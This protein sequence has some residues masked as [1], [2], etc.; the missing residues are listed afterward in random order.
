[1]KPV[2]LTTRVT[3][4]RLGHILTL[5]SLVLCAGV[6][7]L[8]PTASYAADGDD[9]AQSVSSDEVVD[10]SD[11]VIT[12]GHVDLGPKMV[13]GTWTVL[14]RDDSGNTPVWRDVERTVLVVNDA[15]LL[16]APTDAPYA[17]MEATPGEKW[18]VIPQTENHSSVWLGWNTQDPEVTR[19]V[20]R[21]VTMSIGPVEGP[22]KS[23]MFLQNGT[24]GEPLLLVDGQKKEAQDVWV[25]VNTHVHA[26]WVFTK[27]GVYLATLT[28]SA[29]TRDGGQVSETKTLRFAVG[30]QTDPAEALAATRAGEDTPASAQP[31]SDNDSSMSSPTVT[32]TL[33][34][35]YWWV[36]LLVLAAGIGLVFL[37]YRRR[38]VEAERR[39]AQEEARADLQHDSGDTADTPDT[40]D[41]K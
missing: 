26:N 18:W 19:L 25:D 34:G 35:S 6:L 20:D 9:L 23:W 12:A 8:W 29:K 28:F 11:A 7:P 37:V 1:M 40:K 33:V 38:T 16:D 21:G 30:D 15:A 10:T 5:L 41:K 36:Y 3:S 17:F 14:A 27:P 4:L 2:A 24:F 13:D 32:N 31:Q 39:Q 22:G